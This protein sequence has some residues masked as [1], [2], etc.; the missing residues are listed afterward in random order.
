MR[1]IVLQLFGFGVSPF[2][3]TLPFALWWC[4][5]VVSEVVSYT[6]IST[7]IN[8]VPGILYLDRFLRQKTATISVQTCEGTSI[9]IHFMLTATE[10]LPKLLV[11]TT[12]CPYNRRCLISS[13][14][15]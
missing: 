5:A 9:E 1:I 2:A 15:S 11:S 10:I 3:V 4:Q 14:R 6:P 8:V 7:L 12:S 13:Y